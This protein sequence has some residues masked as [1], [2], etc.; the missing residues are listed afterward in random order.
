MFSTSNSLCI[1]YI[2]GRN[3]I[4][5]SPW[6]NNRSCPTSP[7][8]NGWFSCWRRIMYTRISRY[9]YTWKC[10]HTYCAYL[11]IYT[12]YVYDQTRKLEPHTKATH[13]R[14][15]LCWPGEMSTATAVG[16]Y[17][18][19]RCFEFFPLENNNITP[20]RKQFRIYIIF[21]IFRKFDWAFYRTCTT[22]LLIRLLHAVYC[23]I[24]TYYIKGS[25]LLLL[26]RVKRYA[27]IHQ[28]QE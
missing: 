24:L 22:V 27:T 12:V 2:S 8:T 26:Q 6:R 4:A 17:A 14:V 3:R 19:N 7:Q 5:W 23:Y 15:R 20:P 10:I 28:Q 25:V 13:H 18:Q 9:V 1:L 16:I 21:N 11:Y